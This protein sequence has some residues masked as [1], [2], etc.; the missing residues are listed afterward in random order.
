MDHLER[1]KTVYYD[2]EKIVDVQ[3][4]GEE[5]PKFEVKWLGFEETSC[6]P[7]ADIYKDCPELVREFVESIKDKK[8]RTNIR[9]TLRL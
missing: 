9:S 8:I 7:I 2:V 6:E 3:V 4:E 1:E 5:G